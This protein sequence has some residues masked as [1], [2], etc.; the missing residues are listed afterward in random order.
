M[1]QIIHMVFIFYTVLLVAMLA[2]PH[3]GDY[4]SRMD[5]LEPIGLGLVIMYLSRKKD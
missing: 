4:H 5:H 2:V 3:G 1:R